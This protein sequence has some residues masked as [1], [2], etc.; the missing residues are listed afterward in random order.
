MP[1]VLF[2]CRG[3]P[4]GGDIRFHRLKLCP[5]AVYHDKQPTLTCDLLFWLVGRLRF[6]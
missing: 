1:I 4:H 3:L 5:A 6:G 2:L